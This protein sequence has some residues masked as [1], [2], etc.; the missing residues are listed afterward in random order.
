MSFH[1]GEI[2]NSVVDKNKKENNMGKNKSHRDVFRLKMIYTVY[3]T[4]EKFVV[5]KI[6]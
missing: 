1:S 2:K 6:V 5:S 4:I 3:S